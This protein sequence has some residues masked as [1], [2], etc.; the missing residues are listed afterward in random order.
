MER[1]R[2]FEY[3]FNPNEWE[4]DSKFGIYVHKEAQLGKGCRLSRNIVINKDVVVGDGVTIF[5]G[6]VIY[7][8]TAIGKNTQLLEY[9]ILGRPPEIA[10]TITR[11]LKENYPPLVIGNNCLIGPFAKVYRG[12]II[13]NRVSIF[14]FTTIREECEIGDEA[15]LA[16]SV[17]VNYNTK[18]GPRT[19]VMHSTHL[20]GR[21][22][23][24]EDV[25][26]SLHVGSTNDPMIEEEE[27]GERWRGPIIRKRAVIGAGVMLAPNIEIGEGSHIAM[28][29]VVTRNI[30]PFVLA[31]GAPARVV[32][33]LNE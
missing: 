25:F 8:E 9:I 16:P 18:I 7:P 10:G 1:Q 15:V 23:I 28:Q 22:I 32:K 3:T 11:R 33:R 31:A 19:R 26:I 12:T 29:S 20:T 13:G 4:I 5:D 2:P 27:G 21:M 17:T 30:P 24:E 6:V 14:E